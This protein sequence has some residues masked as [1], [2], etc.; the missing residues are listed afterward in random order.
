MTD[1]GTAFWPFSLALYARSGVADACLRLQDEAGADVNMLLLGFWR[2]ENG[3]AGWAPGEIERAQS[4]VAPVNAVLAPYRQ[5]RRALKRLGEID[6]AATGLYDE[7]K[8]LEL[9]LEEIA[10]A[11]LVPLARYSAAIQHEGDVRRAAQRHLDAYLASLAQ[12]D[13]PAGAALL[14]AAF[15]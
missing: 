5:A 6:S 8:R 4:A 11:Y 10:Q 13:H 2:A 7:A 1:S 3:L 15:S 12:P 14:A 9:R